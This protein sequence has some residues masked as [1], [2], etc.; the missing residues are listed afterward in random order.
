MILSVTVFGQDDVPGLEALTEHREADG[1]RYD[2]TT[3]SF[4]ETDADTRA[5]M[6]NDAILDRVALLTPAAEALHR[7]DVWVRFF[8][9]LPHG[10]ETIRAETVRA[11][12]AV[13]ATL[14][15]DA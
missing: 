4:D 9:T 3:F 2:I 12:A 8:L 11:L 10:A 13:N 6:L 7:T 15:I 5:D 1:I 14:W